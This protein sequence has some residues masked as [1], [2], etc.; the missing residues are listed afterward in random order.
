MESGVKLFFY[1]F[2]TLL[3]KL[4]GIDSRFVIPVTVCIEACIQGG[5]LFII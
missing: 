2:I 5:R 4:T 3:K 1:S